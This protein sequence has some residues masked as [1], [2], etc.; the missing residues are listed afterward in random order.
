[1]AVWFAIRREGTEPTEF[2]DSGP[3]VDVAV[4]VGVDA[5]LVCGII[6][7]VAG[8]ATGEAIVGS[9]D[10]PLVEVAASVSGCGNASEDCVFAG[11]AFS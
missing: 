6:E 4:G 10:V 7:S 2:V 1:M 11:S 3:E 9:T 5:V 8:K